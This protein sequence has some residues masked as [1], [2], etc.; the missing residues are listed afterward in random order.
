MNLTGKGAPRVNYR[1]WEPPGGRDMAE[2]RRERKADGIGRE[3][4]KA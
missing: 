4:A 2:N 3:D 1:G